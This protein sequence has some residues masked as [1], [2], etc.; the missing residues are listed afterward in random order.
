M[1]TSRRLFLQLSLAL[2]GGLTIGFSS[3]AK[4]QDAVA[5]GNYITIK[6]D[7][8][9][10]ILAKNPEIGQGI[11]TALAMIIADEL[12]ADWNDVTVETAPV[13]EARFGPQR[14]GGSMAIT[15]N[16]T[17]MRQVGASAR[18]VLLQ[19][20]ASRLNVPISE[21]TTSEGRIIHSPSGR[22]LSYG[23]VAS[24]A[25][26]LP[27]PALSEVKL[28]SPSEFN[29]IG[30][31]RQGVDNAK[32]LTGEPI[33]GI[34]MELPG[35]KYAVLLKAP[36]YG[37]KIKSFDID[38]AKTLSG[39]ENVFVI[40]GKEGTHG[41]KPSIALIGTNWWL[42]NN[43]KQQLNV[44]WDD[45]FGEAH[46]S[47]IY[48]AKAHELL[49]SAGEVIVNNGNV[50][51]AIAEAKYKVEANY[52]TP[53]LAHITMEP[54]N[55]TALVTGDSIEIWAPT[56]NPMPGAR[57]V[58]QQ[59][60]FALDKIKINMR[61][62]GGGFGRRLENDY[63][64][65]AA[66]IAKLSG[67]PI[68]LLWSREDD[69]G[70]DFYRSGNYHHLSAGI[71]AEGMINY[72]NVHGVTFSVGGRVAQGASINGNPI[73]P[74][75]SPNYKFEQSL[76]ETIIPTG[77]MRAPTSNSIAF[78]HESFI[79]E[80]AHAS[81][82]D[83]LAFRL[84][85]L[86][87]GTTPNIPTS[88]DNL[89]P[90]P[91]FNPHRMKEVLQRVAEISNWGANRP[92][93]GI[94]YG[95]ACYFCHRGYFAHV[96]KVKVM[97]DGTWRVLKVWAVGDVGSV[98]VNPSGARSQVEGSIIDGIGQMLNEVRFEKGH[99]KPNNLYDFKLMR[100][101]DA[102]KIEVGFITN[103]NDPTGLGE[104]ALP[105]IIPAV[106]NAIFAA[107]GARIRNLPL[108]PEKILAA[109]S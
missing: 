82:Q 49:S 61:R 37:A 16:W 100:I 93:R 47:A 80:L 87:N 4:A 63:I 81:N 54:Q 42:L 2:G 17:L 36:V 70:Y 85:H 6:P 29:I 5:I 103:E 21:L 74:F 22:S 75:F 40:E 7:G 83:P 96:A 51:N 86:V 26:S 48:D 11:K 30:T 102:P 33:F 39:V 27:A 73:P 90:Q 60:G 14:A 41:L 101:K 58:N 31:P 19:A 1:K 13:D 38:H 8:K 46:D 23:D 9:I 77:F 34:D 50:E 15:L 3:T 45:A 43:A 94:G 88:F 109:K 79:D 91:Q 98:I 107:S 76:I 108:T 20:A 97:A 64:V 92:R 35:L 104:P 106:A 78:V 95:L 72:Y 84:K 28:K 44:E 25:A 71:N 66:A 53:F 105:P 56:Q 32:V 68:K 10:I 67:L 65:E 62:A 69:I 99:A 18:L 59:L 52:T 89:P 24:E 57:L 12:D 55:C